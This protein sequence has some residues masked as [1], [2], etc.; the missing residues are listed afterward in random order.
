MEYIDRMVS[1]VENGKCYKWTPFL[2]IQNVLDGSEANGNMIHEFEEDIDPKQLKCRSTSWDQ[3]K[4]LFKRRWKQMWRDS[5][6]IWKINFQCTKE[7]ETK[8][9]K[10]QCYMKLKIYMTLCM[11]VLVGCLYQGCGNDATK[12]LFNFGFCFTVTIAFMYNP[13]MPVLLQCKFSLG[14]QFSQY[15][16]SKLFNSPSS[17]WNSSTETWTFQ[18]MVQIGTIL[19][20]FITGSTSHTNWIVR[21]LF[22]YNVPNVSQ[23]HASSL[24]T[25]ED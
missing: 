7:M 17:Q 13:L 20:G 21:H 16:D 6:W 12:A 1:T 5:V 18:S 2:A 8:T 24:E 14:K 25:I 3:F 10:F 9:L 23:C 4:V 15:F 22:K 11:A 19:L